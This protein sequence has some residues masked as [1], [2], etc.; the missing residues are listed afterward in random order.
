MGYKGE[1]EGGKEEGGGEREGGKEEG[2]GRRGKE[3]EERK[4]R[5][6]EIITYGRHLW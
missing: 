5:V 4:R 6:R 1:R 3:E 2:G